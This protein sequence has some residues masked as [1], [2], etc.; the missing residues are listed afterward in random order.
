MIDIYICEDSEEQ[1]E[2][3]TRYVESAVL[4][5]EYDMKVKI[6]TNDPEKIIAELKLSDNTGI[7]FLDIDLQS[8]KNGILLAKEIREY[9]PR[10]FII[11]VTSHSEMSFLTFQYKVEALDFILKDEPKQLQ[12]R[13]GECIEDVYQK[14]KKITRGE[15]KTI[16]IRRG[17][18]KIILEYDNIMFFETSVNEHKLI[19]HTDSKN[20]E[21][22]GKMKDIEEEVGGGFIRCHRA[23]LVNK[24]NIKE[25][26][27]AEKIIIMKNQTN[28]PISYRM[29]RK[30][31]K[32][33]NL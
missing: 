17:S 23:Y 11:F 30:V 12:H 15:G 14:Y 33:I 9:D 2:A 3:I 20:I 19:V 16:S 24:K 13:I 7:Y 5:R 28:C 4:I 31:K 29:L 22:F 26:N 1:R 25:I 6:T 8:T 21:F 10:G 27:Y 32:N 18:R